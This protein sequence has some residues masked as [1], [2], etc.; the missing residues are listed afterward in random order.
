MLNNRLITISAA[1]IVWS[2]VLSV[3]V[4][5][6]ENGWRSLFSLRS[7]IGLIVVLLGPVLAYW[8]T[9]RNRAKRVALVVTAIAT[10]GAALQ[11]Y[12]MLAQH[13]L[14]VLPLAL[15]E[16]VAITILWVFSWL[17]SLLD[18]SHNT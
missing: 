9:L 12:L 17:S 11:S 10:L 8:V 3:G 18:E 13:G 4:L 5:V 16:F 15:I 1:V 2:F 7:G 14:A 6:A